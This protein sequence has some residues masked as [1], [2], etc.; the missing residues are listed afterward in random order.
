M[1][2]PYMF[3]YIVK[4]HI[5]IIRKLSNNN[6][7]DNFY[8][9]CNS[10]VYDTYNKLKFD[11]NIGSNAGPLTVSPTKPNVVTP[12]LCATNVKSTSDV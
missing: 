11:N 3:S 1:G 6:Q 2:I 4:N 5:N 12:T 8:L 7:V 10:I 9:D